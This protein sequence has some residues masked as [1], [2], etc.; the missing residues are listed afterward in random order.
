M[1]S[2]TPFCIICPKKLTHNGKGFF[3]IC[4]LECFMCSSKNKKHP[5]FQYLGNNAYSRKYNMDLKMIADIM[6]EHLIILSL[7]S[8]IQIHHY[9]IPQRVQTAFLYDPAMPLLGTYW[10]DLKQDLKKILAH[11]RVHSGIIP[12]AKGW[13]QLQC[14]LTDK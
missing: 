5:I 13:Q 7:N 1:L 10:Q 11:T 2:K 3:S 8:R 6:Q 14:P 12:R 4:S 9:G